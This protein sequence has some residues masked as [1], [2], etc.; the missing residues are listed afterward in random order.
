MLEIL[1]LMMCK[2]NKGVFG[3]FLAKF[4]KKYENVGYIN[5]QSNYFMF[6]LLIIYLAIAFNQKKKY[7]VSPCTLYEI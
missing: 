7:F 4:C 3:K 5:S 2:K 6:C 1:K